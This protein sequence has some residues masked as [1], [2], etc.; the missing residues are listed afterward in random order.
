MTIVLGIV[1]ALLGGG[2]GGCPASTLTSQFAGFLMAVVGAVVV[3]LISPCV[4]VEPDATLT[5][6]E[7]TT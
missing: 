5:S 6:T 2:S 1:G 7:G 4:A 3:L